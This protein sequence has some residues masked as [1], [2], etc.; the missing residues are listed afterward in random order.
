MKTLSNFLAACFLI[1][2]L[3]S[4][5]QNTDS[6]LFETQF[7]QDVNKTPEKPIHMD[8]VKLDQKVIQKTINKL[9]ENASTIK[10]IQ[11][12]IPHFLDG[13]GNCSVTTQDLGYDL[14]YIMHKMY[15]GYGTYQVEVVCFKDQVMKL[16][17][18]MSNYQEIIHDHLLEIIEV[19]FDCKDGELIYE[20]TFSNNIESYAAING[21]LYLDLNDTNVRRMQA[22]NY[23]TDAM[24]NGIFTEPFYTIYWS[25]SDIASH[26]N[27]LIDNKDYEGLKAILFSANPTGR[28]FAA[29]ALVY[30]EDKF[31]YV[32]DEKVVVRMR[33]TLLNAQ[34][35]RSGIISC[36]ANQMNYNYHDVVAGFDAMLKAK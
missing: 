8:W 30:M 24:S 35:I 10:E 34:P 17:L 18:S 13:K 32:P 15:G 22:I 20:K 6:I 11:K 9:P 5:G 2:S 26:L 33:E 29:Q 14:K 25:G 16:H 3:V 19:P 28:L 1:L 4:F 21:N 7:C 36:W 12:L 31:S 27:Y 23:F